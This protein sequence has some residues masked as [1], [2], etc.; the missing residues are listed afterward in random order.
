MA[1]LA[2]EN[3][4]RAQAHQRRW[5]NQ[6][7]RQR[8]LTPRDQV[9]VLLPVATNKLQARWQGPFTVV[10]KSSPAN[11]TIEMPGRKKKTPHHP[12]QHVEE[13]K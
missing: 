7:A 5:Y 3:L 1:E 4:S 2:K 10:R 12:R 9:L 6:T 8:E 13:M 11:Y